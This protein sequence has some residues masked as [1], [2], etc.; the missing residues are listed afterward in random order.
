MLLNLDLSHFHLGLVVGE[1]PLCYNQGLL[2]EFGYHQFFGDS[3][4]LGFVL[5]AG[6]GLGN[7]KAKDPD[8]VW[9]VQVGLAVKIWQ[10]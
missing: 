6:V 1:N 9:D 4:I 7:F 10:R 3:K 5:G 8:L 2:C